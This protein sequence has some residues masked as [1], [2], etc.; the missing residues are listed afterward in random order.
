MALP[1]G[2]T[3]FCIF[4][5]EK[6]KYS[7][8][9]LARRTRGLDWGSQPGTSKAY[10]TGEILDLKPFLPGQ[11]Q[12]DADDERTRLAR[13]LYLTYGVTAVVSY[14][15]Q[16]L[17]MRAAPSAGGLYPAEVYV[18]SRGT[19]TLPAGL[20]N[21]QVQ[22]HSLVRF[23]SGEVWAEA[24][25]ACFEHP[26]FRDS[27][28]AI[29]VSAVFFRS[30]WRYEDRAYRRIFLDSGHLVGNLELAAALERYHVHLVTGFCD[31][32]LNALLFLPSQ[33][34]AVI[35][36]GVLRDRTSEPVAGWTALPSTVQTDYPPVPEGQRLTYLHECSKL[37]AKPVPASPSAGEDKYNF[38]FCL[39]VPV[40]TAPLDWRGSLDEAILKRRSTRQYADE[41]LTLD[42]LR[43]L[44]DF[45]YQP[46][47]YRD[48]RLDP[49]PEYAHLHLLS[50]FVAV[51]AVGGLEEGCYYYA[52]QAQELRQ[53]RFKNFRREI[54][55]LCLG[56]ELGRDSGA[57]VFHTADLPAA[58]ALYGERVYRTLHLD[59]GH[60][61]QRLNL[62]AV[63]LGLGVSGIA[64]FFD[65]QVNQLLDIPAQEAVLYITTLGRPSPGAA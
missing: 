39:K 4:Y 11:P 21:Y 44:L 58:V 59:S 31:D 51:L 20:Y 61:A 49:D 2:G 15:E 45:T 48:Q 36:V 18:L 7:P 37:D 40:E 43:A 17:Y 60:L 64:G 47:H 29:V 10:K 57:V 19:G 34:E 23:W 62:A 5:H 13:L 33:E 46:Q 32:A 42:E 53:M 22:S 1:D 50:T 65:D 12:A 56:Q 25:A 28:I 8:E 55:H 54:H 27:S 24:S 6:T 63:H 26:A 41:A 38:P 14:P 30:A 9:S 3:P 52:P 16:S 35:A